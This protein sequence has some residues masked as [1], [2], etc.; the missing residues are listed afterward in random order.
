MEEPIPVNAKSLVFFYY[1]LLRGCA[2]HKFTYVGLN[3][4]LNFI[5][6]GKCGWIILNENLINN[7]FL[8]FQND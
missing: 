1:F 3:G 4:V 6:K 7:I 2:F 8:M 5:E